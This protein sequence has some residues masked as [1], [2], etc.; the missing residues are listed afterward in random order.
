MASTTFTKVMDFVALV[1]LL[2]GIC[3]FFSGIGR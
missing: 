3:L 2:G 1:A